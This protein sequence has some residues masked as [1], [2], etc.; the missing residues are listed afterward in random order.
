MREHSWHSDDSDRALRRRAWEH[1]LH[2]YDSSRNGAVRGCVGPSE[3]EV[4]GVSGFGSLLGPRL[5]A[6]TALG[7]LDAIYT[8][9]TDSA[10][11][12][13]PTLWTTPFSA[14]LRAIFGTLTSYRLFRDYLQV[15]DL[16]SLRTVIGEL[17]LLKE[18]WATSYRTLKDAAHVL[19]LSVHGL[20]F[21]SYPQPTLLSLKELI[22]LYS[23]SDAKT[24]V[25]GLIG[26]NL[27]AACAVNRATLPAL[28]RGR[29]TEVCP[30]I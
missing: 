26:G 18:G 4:Y 13:L 2:M 5:G 15:T 19:G 20:L 14:D 16:S 17:S 8:I 9:N 25:A 3:S 21:A 7:G 27:T 22:E 1:V 24:V 12:T 29:L 23:T 10:L 28:L 11:A 6:T 30:S